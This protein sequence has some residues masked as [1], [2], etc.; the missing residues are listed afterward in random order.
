MQKK[1]GETFYERL[2]CDK[3]IKEHQKRIREEEFDGMIIDQVKNIIM[4]DSL[5]G[6]AMDDGC[7]DG[8]EVRYTLLSKKIVDCVKKGV[9]ES[10]K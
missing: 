5:A 3:T 4:G 6:R 1:K 7:T 10:K 2:R 9:S 8:F